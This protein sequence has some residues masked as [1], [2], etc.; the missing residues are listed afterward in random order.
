MLGV[1]SIREA[2]KKVRRTLPD[3]LTSFDVAQAVVAQLRD[4]PLPHDTLHALCAAWHWSKGVIKA[5]TAK[6]R[7]FC[8]GNAQCD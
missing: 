2:V 3:L 6:A 5:T 1:G 4:V 7:Q 8:A